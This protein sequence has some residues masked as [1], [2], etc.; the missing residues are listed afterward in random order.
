MQ[1]CLL[2]Q[3][4]WCGNR[5][6][7]RG[8]RPQVSVAAVPLRSGHTAEL[9]AIAVDKGCQEGYAG[10]CTL[11]HLYQA[12]AAH[13]LRACLVPV[14]C[15]ACRA[16]WV[17]ASLAATAGPHGFLKYM[18]PLF[19]WMPVLQASCQPIPGQHSDRQQ[20]CQPGSSPAAAPLA[21]RPASSSSTRPL[22]QHLRWSARWRGCWC[23]D[24]K[25]QWQQQQPYSKW[26]LAVAA[27]AAAAAS[28]GSGGCATTGGA[29]CSLA[30][31]SG[32]DNA[33]SSHAA[34][35]SGSLAVGSSHTPAK[36]SASMSV[37][38]HMLL[39]H[40]AQM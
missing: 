33:P 18:P 37:Q 31:A 4:A 29:S 23:R 22:P 36:I 9:L 32:N 30:A 16:F 3:P 25:Q 5:T 15:F 1:A 7:C 21:A 6:A 35:V 14:V 28:A 8:S 11:P 40:A 2:T 10:V 38:D 26:Q 20:Q 13:H 27:E 17:A 24:S 39:P 12:T 19:F 34:P